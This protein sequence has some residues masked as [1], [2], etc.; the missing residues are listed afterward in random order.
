[1][2]HAEIVSDSIAESAPVSGPFIPQERDDLCAELREG[3]VVPIVGDVFMHQGPQPLDRIEMG[4]VLWKETQH[5]LA[6]GRRKPLS[7]DTGFVIIGVVGEDV[8]DALARMNA[9]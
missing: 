9:L 3:L 7:D 5:A 6:P 2:D 8:D 1:M 4:T